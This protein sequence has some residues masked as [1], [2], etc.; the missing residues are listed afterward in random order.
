M[1]MVWGK[2]AERS[3]SFC[4][5]EGVGIRCGDIRTE[6]TR[7]LQ[8]SDLT[9]DEVAD[10]FRVRDAVHLEFLIAPCSLNVQDAVADHGREESFYVRRYVLDARKQE[11][12]DASIEIAILSN[13]YDAVRGNHPQRKEEFRYH[14][15]CGHPDEEQ[16]HAKQESYDRV[17]EI[18]SDCRAACL[19][20]R[21]HYRHHYKWRDGENDK[22]NEAQC[23]KERMLMHRLRYRLTRF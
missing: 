20:E 3:F 19:R 23:D 5:N 10:F 18:N 2:T 11:A 12:R 14:R 15:E 4:L 8:G 9:H 16:V 13:I 22:R 1:N 7:I 6:S 21:V 17:A